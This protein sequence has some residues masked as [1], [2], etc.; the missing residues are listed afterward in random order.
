MKAHLIY[1]S[2]D[3]FNRDFVKELHSFGI[4]DTNIISV[5]MLGDKCNPPMVII[6]EEVDG[7]AVETI[8]KTQ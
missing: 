5:K 2:I 7:K 6:I 4:T 8:L 1:K 3:E